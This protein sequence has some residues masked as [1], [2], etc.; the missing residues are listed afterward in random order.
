MQNSWQN[1]R[2]QYC[3]VEITWTCSR[4]MNEA[5]SISQWC[6]SYDRKLYHFLF[7]RHILPLWSKNA[8]NITKWHIGVFIHD[9]LSLVF[10]KVHIR[11]HC[12]LGTTFHLSWS[13]HSHLSLFYIAPGIPP[14][15]GGCLWLTFSAPPSSVCS[16]PRNCCLLSWTSF[17][18]F[19]VITA[20]LISTHITPNPQ[21]HESSRKT[22]NKQSKAKIENQ[23]SWHLK[24]TYL[25]LHEQKM[26]EKST[27]KLY[28]FTSS[29][30]S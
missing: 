8:T 23:I 1:T 22:P 11:C 12:S 20:K 9:I 27:T 19:A 5:K 29:P 26:N 4:I 7:L 14:R 2:S 3:R 17:E 15:W 24:I 21:T 30:S 28:L 18:L 16:S 6:I 13:F 10:A 25:S